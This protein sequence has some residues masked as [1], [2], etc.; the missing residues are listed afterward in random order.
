MDYDLRIGD[1]EADNAY[2][3]AELAFM[4]STPTTLEGAAAKLSWL[5]EEMVDVDAFTFDGHEQAI[6]TVRDFLLREAS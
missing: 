2:N 5:L 3:A 4:R 6:R 1:E